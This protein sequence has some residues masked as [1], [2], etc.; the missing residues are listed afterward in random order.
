MFH[1]PLTAS[2]AFVAAGSPGTRT[3]SPIMW[4]QWWKGKRGPSLISPYTCEIV[5]D[6]KSMFPLQ[7]KFI[8]HPLS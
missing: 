6:H 3:S 8:W 7:M 2:A 1:F 5:K 4:R